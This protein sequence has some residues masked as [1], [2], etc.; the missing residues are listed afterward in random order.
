MTTYW[1]GSNRK[2]ANQHQQ[3]MKKSHLLDERQ[4]QINFERLFQQQRQH[5]VVAVVQRRD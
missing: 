1:F 5:P 3:K 2:R 4:Q